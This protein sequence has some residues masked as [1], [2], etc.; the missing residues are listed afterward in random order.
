MQAGQLDLAES[1]LR[2]V[3]QRHPHHPDALH[4]LGLI[5]GQRGRVAE[6]MQLIEAAIRTF[7]RHADYH[8]NLGN[9]LKGVGNLEAAERSYR[10]ALELS[11]DHPLA[12]FNLGTLLQDSGRAA[13]AVVHLEAVVRQCPDP[14]AW[15]NLAEAL[16]STGDSARA[17]ECYLKVLGQNPGHGLAVR[18]LGLL[19]AR[20][21]RPAEALGW[22]EKALMQFPQD[23]EIRRSLVTCLARLGRLGEAICCLEAGSPRTASVWHHLGYLHARAGNLDVAE[24]CLR[25]AVEMDSGLAEAQANLG[26]LMQSQGRHAEAV[27]CF[28]RAIELGHDVG[29]L[30]FNLA[31][32]LLMLG[33][34]EEGWEL[35]ERRWENPELGLERPRC[36][37]PEW[38]GEPLAGKTILLYSEQGFGDSI[39]YI[40]YARLLA[41]AG[42]RVKVV[43]QEP[44]RALF[45]GVDGV[46]AVIRSGEP[47]GFEYYCSLQSLPHRFR[48]RLDTVPNV[49]PYL[50]VTRDLAV[51][52]HSRPGIKVGLAW[53]GNS[54]N[55]IARERD[56]PLNDWLGLCQVPA[57]AFFSLQ[58]GCSGEDLERIQRAG[59]LDLGAHIKDF[60]D[61]LAL[62]S[63]LD[64]VITVDTALA[65]LCGGLGKA[66]WVL[67]CTRS[68]WR[69]GREGNRCAWYPTARLYRQRIAGQWSDALSAVKQDLEGL[70]RG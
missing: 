18:N 20:T 4:L 57:C 53:S 36:S 29:K 10:V 9:L 61:T 31:M 65:H 34:W 3:L 15:V 27:P 30:R 70:A 38:H 63:Q 28:R 22:L 64:L 54:R 62:A 49:I 1:G 43:T 19:M 2:Q 55:P 52:A 13:E 26:N 48:T 6:A 42:A 7:P 16:C 23:E 32:A 17:E 41:D 66:V 50:R 14:D 45:S 8:V 5:A 35:L 68:D 46:S 58:L 37:Q 59:V 33:E 51:P 11:A 47:S 40:R 24:S 56:V 12:R 60:A 44:L 21:Q 67:I 25:N 69:W 39:Q